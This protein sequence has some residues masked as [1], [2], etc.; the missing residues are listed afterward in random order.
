M[1]G[2]MPNDD[3]VVP[4]V[5]DLRARIEDDGNSAAVGL[6][7]RATVAGI[8]PE[9]TSVYILDDVSQPLIVDTD[10]DGWCDHINPHLVPTT[11][12]PTQNNQVLKVRL[13]GVRGQGD[14]DYRDDLKGTSACP[15]PDTAVAPEW[16]CPGNQPLMTIAGV[17]G[18]PIIYT[19]EPITKARCMGSQ[20]DTYGNNITEGWKCVAVQ[21]ADNGGNTSVSPP[22]R[23]YVKYDG[24]GAG[25]KAGAGLGAPPACTG[26]YDKSAD[27]VTAGTCKTRRFGTVDWIVKDF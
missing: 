20:F 2:D 10:G 17:G 19:L 4:Q 27:T 24:A 22:L 25:Q 5:F 8:D 23:I 26:S 6:K 15:Y 11:R 12:P 7:G 21:T 18:S 1:P 16:V 14:A 13:A 9:A 3:E